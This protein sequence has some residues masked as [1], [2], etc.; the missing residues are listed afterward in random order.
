MASVPLT[1]HFTATWPLHFFS[2]VALIKRYG[3]L[4]CVSA[5]TVP[6][7]ASLARCA[8]LSVSGPLCGAWRFRA[9][10]AVLGVSVPTV[11]CLA[12]PC[13]LCPAWRLWP[14]VPCLASLAHCA[15]L[16]VSVI[17]HFQAFLSII[18]HPIFSI[19]RHY[20]PL[21]SIFIHYQALPPLSDIINS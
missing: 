7:L 5:P 12:F 16:G 14:T 11:P 9:H 15:V 18:K 1:C 20:H 4:C 13:P 3:E 19:M 21:S 2:S 17:V 6:C 10:C 8:V